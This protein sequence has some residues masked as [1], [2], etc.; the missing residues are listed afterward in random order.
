VPDR[1]YQRCNERSCTNRT[2]NRGG[3]CDVHQK[4]NT[5]TQQ[6]E[7]RGHA[8]YHLAVWRTTKRAFGM[9]QP[10]RA[11]CCQ[12]IID[13]KTGERCLQ[14]ATICDHVIPFRGSWELFI[15]GENFS[16]LQG[17]CRLHHAQKTTAEGRE[18]PETKE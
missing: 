10:E 15:G 12:A 3:Y 16:N 7:D 13:P 1:L 17:M 4:T 6:Q 5:V 9:A 8:W 14:P 11:H 18:V 2:N